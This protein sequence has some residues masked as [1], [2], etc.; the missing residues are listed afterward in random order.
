MINVGDKRTRVGDDGCVMDAVLRVTS[1]FF[2][3]LGYIM[4]G[5]MRKHHK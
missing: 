5:W 3:F 2:Y 4:Y 1:F